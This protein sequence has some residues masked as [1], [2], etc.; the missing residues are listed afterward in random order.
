MTD[1]DVPETTPGAA[2]EHQT[3][4]PPTGQPA[5]IEIPQTHN[6]RGGGGGNPKRLRYP[7]KDDA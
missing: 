4:K 1:K 5:P 7:R 3:P 2:D 6:P